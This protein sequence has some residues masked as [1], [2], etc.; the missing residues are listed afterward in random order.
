MKLLS[1]WWVLAH[2]LMFAS[3]AGG[4]GCAHFPVAHQPQDEASVEATETPTWTQVALINPNSVAYHLEQIQ[5]MPADIIVTTETSLAS[6]AQSAVPADL[7]GG[8]NSS[9]GAPIAAGASGGVGVIS[10]HEWRLTK[11][12]PEAYPEI[13]QRKAQ[14]L[15]DSGRL[16]HIVLSPGDGAQPVAF[17]VYY[18]VSG[19]RQSKVKYKKNEENLTL[20]FQLAALGGG[21]RTGVL[22]GFNVSPDESAVIQRVLATGEWRDVV[23]DFDATQGRTPANTSFM[24]D[25]KPSRLAFAIFSN[26]LAAQV[27]RAEVGVWLKWRPHRP[28][29]LSLD[30]ASP[31]QMGPT[32]RAP[33]RF[34][35]PDKWTDAQTAELYLM[36]D[37]LIQ[38]NAER[39]AHL[40]LNEDVDGIWTEI[41]RTLEVSLAQWCLVHGKLDQKVESYLGRGLSPTTIL[42]PLIPPVADVE[43]SAETRATQE[44]NKLLN[45]LSELHNLLR[46]AEAGKC[47]SD[48]EIAMRRLWAQC[49]RA[50]ICYNKTKEEGRN[51]DQ[52]CL[53]EAAA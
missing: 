48:Q 25:C 20:I 12:L 9:W 33:L 31:L 22:G 2:L 8:R 16:L 39:W 36:T 46:R 6:G 24:K 13:L 47:S 18:G 1:G 14:A 42:Q 37:E 17:F 40:E 11:I 23:C 32:L 7:R 52:D 10:K 29:Y 27:R 51:Q 50:W 5:D 15:F 38:D 3:R 45:R 30:V 53:D 43:A 4:A 35:L 26:A 41:S 19:A 49:R 21:I 44:N 34:P 28:V